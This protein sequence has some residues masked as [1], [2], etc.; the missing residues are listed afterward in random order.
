MSITFSYRARTP[1]GTSVRGTMRAL[2]RAEALRALRERMLIASQVEPAL[3]A[4]GI[5]RI[6]ARSK[7]SERLALFR[8]YAAL[9]HAGVDFSTTM[10]LLTQQA[11]TP[12]MREALASIR[13]EV[14][15]GGEKLWT[16]MSHRPGE[17]TDLEVAM[18]AAGEEAGNREDVLERLA[19]FLE[20]DERLRKKLGSAMFY[21]AIVCA[22]ALGI[23]FY[24]FA[25]VVPEFAR[26]FESLD[27]ELSPA[28]AATLAFDRLAANPF[29]DLAL[30]GGACAGALLA[31]RALRTSEGALALDVLRLRL[32]IVGDTIRKS[33]LARLCRVLATLLQSGVNA[34][35]ALEVA[36]PVAESP[37]YA[38]AVETARER[39]AD[40][41]SASLEEALGATG[42]IPP[43]LLG[44][45]RVGSAAGN[46]PEM[47]V[48]IAEY[49]EDDVESVL[50]AAPAAVQTAVTLGLGAIVS[51]IVYLVYVPLSTLSASIH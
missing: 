7:P 30:A 41:S 50:S 33:I 1:G 34:V 3:P 49:Y 42:R 9:E 32:P 10:T 22:A 17:F 26:L 45:V 6:F 5:G 13:S 37:I 44:F 2:N 18:I 23:S 36:V 47:L 51:V 21:P 20:R 35:R 46:L 38:A 28:L 29:L 16:A 24:L 39:L 4:F 15:G 27:V 40:G 19:R 12:R 48:K 14:E 11:R 43:L 8:A 25:V 31:V